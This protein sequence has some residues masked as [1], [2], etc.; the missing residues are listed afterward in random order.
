MK[1]KLKNYLANRP[2]GFKADFARKIGISKSFLRQIETGQSRIPI[3]L[4]KKIE[5]VTD[6]AVKKAELRPDVWG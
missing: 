4:A 3:Y 5:I 1:L 6:K 2:R